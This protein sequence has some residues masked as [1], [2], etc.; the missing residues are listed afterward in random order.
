[1]AIESVREIFELH[2]PKRF[3]KRPELV[4]KVNASYKFVVTG[5]D[6]STWMVDMTQPGGSVTE[7]D[8]DAN[9]TI[10]VDATN[11]LDIMSGKL[12]GQVAFMTGKI[13]VSGDM[14]LA[15][16]LGSVLG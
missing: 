16:K 7:E 6:A 8:K 15:M 14:A 13:K 1:M 5:E 4:E 11:L 10:T 12:N 2:L 9:C 3:E